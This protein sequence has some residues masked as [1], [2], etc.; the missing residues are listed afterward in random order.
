MKSKLVISLVLSSLFAPHVFA[1]D[2]S[3]KFSVR[4]A[5]LID[6]ETFVAEKEQQSPAYMMMGGWI[7][8]YFTGLNQMSSQTYDLTPFQSTE[9]IATIVEN[10][11]KQNPSS[12]LFSVLSSIAGQLAEQR[13][14]AESEMVRINVEEKS[15]VLYRETIRRMQESLAALG[16]LTEPVSGE[17]TENTLAGMQR[18]Q[19]SIAFEATGF[20]DQATLWKLFAQNT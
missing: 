11:C 14:A 9:L 4:G 19:R 12:R 6:C 3:G 7:D 5:G 13:L 1:G 8:G 16:Y 20:P 15:T 17:F 10:H 18:F 2:D